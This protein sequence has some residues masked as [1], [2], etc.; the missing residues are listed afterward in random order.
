MKK[1]ENNLTVVKKNDL[2]ENFVFNATEL[3]LQILNYAV[4][5][6]NPRWENDNAIYRILIPDLVKIFKKNNNRSWEQYRVALSRLMK[7]TYAYDDDHHKHI[8]NLIIR[9]TSHKYDKT[10]LEFKF[11]GYI[12]KRISNLTKLFTQYDIK[13]IAMFKSRYAFMLYEFFK[14]KLSKNNNKYVQKIE[15]DNFRKNLNL[16][17]KYPI[18]KDLKNNVLEKAKININ[19]HSD[20][21]SNYEIIKTGRTPTHIKFTVKYKKGKQPKIEAKQ[22]VMEH[23]ASLPLEKTTQSNNIGFTEEHKETSKKHLDNLKKLMG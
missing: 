9:T 2:I 21:C 13:N 15:I 14:M 17:D 20:I 1:Q 16:T 11:N 18:F 7:R 3:E 8:E 19:R 10:W 6:T 23:Q 5:T 4:A 22:N 12:S